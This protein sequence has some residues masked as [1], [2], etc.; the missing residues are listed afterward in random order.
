V[1]LEVGARSAD[2]S[3]LLVE[4]DG[5][6]LQQALLNLALNARDALVEPA[7][8]TF[9]LQQAVLTA[10]QPAL[11]EPVPAGDYVMIA[12]TD[13]GCGMPPDVLSQA[14]DPFFTTKDVGRGTGLGLPV[15]LGIVH[16]HHG[17]LTL[18]S[19]PGKGT[20]VGLYLPRLKGAE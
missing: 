6:Q 8:I 5:A 15:V 17:Y 3:P 12:V 14:L 11:P 4:A 19:S 20:R 2:S 1:I 9:T 16:A 13:S 7:P 10:E 18:E